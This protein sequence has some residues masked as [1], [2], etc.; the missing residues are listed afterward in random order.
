MSSD[1]SRD[2][3]VR[4][5]ERWH[6]GDREALGELLAQTEP[7]LRAA[8]GP[9]LGERLRRVEDS[10]DVAQSAVVK[11]LVGGPRFLPASR[12]Q[13]RALMKRIAMNEV[14]D[15]QRRLRTADGGLGSGARSHY[16]DSVLD[17]RADDSAAQPSHVAAKDEERAWVRVAMEL[18]GD[19]ERQLLYAREVDGRDWGDIAREFGYETAD[20]AAKAC[21]RML[22]DVA[23]LVRKLQQGRLKELLPDEDG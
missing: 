16:G 10:A 13:F 6:A 15:R 7:W 17:L 12:G 9:A 20:A 14:I 8:V 22:P 23:K 1:P 2:D 18:L 19:R 21:M 11:F 4:L 5:L 3:T